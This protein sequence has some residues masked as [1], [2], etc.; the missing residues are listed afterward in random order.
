M[1]FFDLVSLVT[2]PGTR[3]S[4]NKWLLDALYMW[5]PIKI[6]LYIETTHFR[7]ILF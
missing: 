6:G 7:N 3:K 5:V 4:L 2:V 1:F